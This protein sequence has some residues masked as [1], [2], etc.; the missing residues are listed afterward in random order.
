MRW[1]AIPLVATVA[2]GA[3]AAQAAGFSL[4]GPAKIAFLYFADK[5]DGGWTQ[6]FDEARPKIEKALDMKIPFVEN[7]PEVA[8]KITPAAET[9]IKR[10]FNVII[11]TAFGYSDTFKELSQKYPKV[12]FLNAS[13]TTNGPNLESFYGRTYE[14]QYLCGMVAGAMSKSGARFCG[15]HPIG[16]STGPSTPMA[17]RSR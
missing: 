8:G 5:G 11:G 3:V 7:V 16:P 10:G 14:S 17:W 9:F 12:A 2:I 1:T 15:A 13:G 6:A 4:P